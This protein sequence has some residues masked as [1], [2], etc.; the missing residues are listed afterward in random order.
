MKHR[1]QLS[2]YFSINPNIL[3]ETSRPRHTEGVK[4]VPVATLV[5]AQH[6]FSS[7]NIY[8]T[9]NIAPLTKRSPNKIKSDNYQCLYS[10]EH[11]M[12]DLQSC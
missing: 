4:M 11:G 2:N 9:T 3:I 10:P 8:L 5:G 6:I 12:E 7:P 1:G